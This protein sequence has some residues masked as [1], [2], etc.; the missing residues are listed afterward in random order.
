MER[1]RTARIRLLRPGFRLGERCCA[2]LGV[3][4]SFA[5]AARFAVVRSL[6]RLG[7]FGLSHVR[8]DM[9]TSALRF[10]EQFLLCAPFDIDAA[11]RWARCLEGHPAQPAGPTDHVDPSAPSG[12]R[13]FRTNV[14]LRPT[15][16]GARA[17]RPHGTSARRSRGLLRRCPVPSLGSARAST[18][19]G[20]I[21]RVFLCLAYGRHTPRGTNTT[22]STEKSRPTAVSQ[23]TR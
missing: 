4:L 21:H 23:P 18:E 16:P 5:R 2:D 6:Q 11:V 3:R 10:V 20:R 9:Y 19:V 7:D 13:F 12:C 17:L 22:W 8:R 1:H 15:R 14:L